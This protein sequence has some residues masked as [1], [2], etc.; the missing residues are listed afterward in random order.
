MLGTG[1]LSEIALGWST[2]GVGDQMSH[3]NVNSGVPKTL[4][5]HLIRWVIATAQFD[6]DVSA[7]P[8]RDPRHRDQPGAG[9]GRR[10]RGPAVHR[11]PD[12][13][14]RAA[15]LLA[16]PHAAARPARRRRSRSSPGT[17]GTTR[18]PGRG[19]STSRPRG[20]SPTTWP[21]S[22]PGSGCSASGS[23]RSPSSSG[24]RCPTGRRCPPAGRCPRAVTG[25]RRRTRR[26]GCGWTSSPRCLRDRLPDRPRPSG[27]G[28][29]RPGGSSPDG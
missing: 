26:R 2:Y 15:R 22:G 4:I 16:V 5:Q 19:R 13:P 28:S 11:G 20:G 17:R 1:D 3:Y 9:A 10:G 25:G 23:S 6:D 14:V 21:R 8:R 24:R 12:R 7:T 18:R 29:A 27:A